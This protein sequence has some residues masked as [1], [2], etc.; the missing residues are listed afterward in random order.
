VSGLPWGKFFWKDWLT[1]PALSVCSLA[2]Q[3]L[4]MRMLCIM[5][6]SEPL[7]HFKLPPT[8]R[9]DS[10]AKQ[11]ARMC[12]ADARQVRPLL[13][14]LE[15]R[16]VLSRDEAGTIVSR[17]MIRDAELSEIGRHAATKGWAKRKGLPKG[18]PNADRAN[19]ESRPSHERNPMPR[20]DS[21]SESPPVGRPRKSRSRRKD[22][23]APFRSGFSE[24]AAGD[25]QET[26]D[27]ADKANPR[28]G[29]AAVVPIAGHLIRRQH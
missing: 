4:W 23:G 8:R 17:R 3:G 13:D 18:Q 28:S 22:G 27:H 2:A 21:E 5:S 19:G 6:M 15:T 12:L 29:G 24:S 26:D 10:D 14:E 9:A 25:M 16:G 20:S 11:I 1:D 7:G